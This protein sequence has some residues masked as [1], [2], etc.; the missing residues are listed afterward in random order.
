LQDHNLD[1][2]RAIERRPPNSVLVGRVGDCDIVNRGK[3]VPVDVRLKFHQPDN[4]NIV[5]ANFEKIAVPTNKLFSKPE[6]NTDEGKNKKLFKKKIP[7]V[8]FQV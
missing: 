6:F 3:D 5:V 8:A 4:G 2:H 1:H 7:V